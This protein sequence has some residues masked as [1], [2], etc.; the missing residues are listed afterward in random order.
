VNKNKKVG[1]I[2]AKAAFIISGAVIALGI[3]L[4]VTNVALTVAFNVG[5]ALLV[6]GAAIIV[7]AKNRPYQLA[8]ERFSHSE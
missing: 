3:V 5:I 6:V 8:S 2:S 7:L 4:I 1:R